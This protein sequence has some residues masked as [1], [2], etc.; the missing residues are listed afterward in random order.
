MADFER[1][2]VDRT[3]AA[4]GI[5]EQ[6]CQI[7]ARLI[8]RHAVA[9]V[10][11]GFGGPV[12]V[13]AGRTIHS[14]QI[15]GWD[16]FPLAQWC[17][18]SLGVPAAVGNDSDL[19][20]LGEARFGAGSGARVVFYSNVGSGIGGSLVIDGELYRGGG[21]ASELGHLRPGL[22]A[23]GE[24][25]SVELA[26]SGWAIATIAKAKA[27]ESPG[28]PAAA[29]LA[30]RC[31]GNLESLSA[32]IVGEAYADGNR[33]AAG[34][35]GDA[36]RT[37]GWA[38]AQMITLVAPQV[39]VIGGGV[40][41]LGE[42]LYLAPLREAV[43]R[44]VFPPLRGAFRLLPAMLGEE[45]VVHGALALATSAHARSASSSPPGAGG[46]AHEP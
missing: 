6:I 19:A 23:T 2:D 7:G 11:I 32:K 4:A 9:A 18:E 40:P 3:R 34:V 10:G 16:D 8:R 12:D 33:L 31:G 22:D 37:Y 14:F 29:D 25:Q 13:S 36:I 43:D 45:V 17:R 44:Y 1:F 21:V 39:V 24:H 42:S 28:D 35:F 20:G 15:D 27:A 46:S 41:L 26:A 38:L 30:A 5:R